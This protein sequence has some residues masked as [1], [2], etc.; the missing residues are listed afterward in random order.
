MGLP[1]PVMTISC[2]CG[3]IIQIFRSNPTDIDTYWCKNCAIR[4]TVG[5]GDLAEDEDEV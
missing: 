5:P 2:S 3:K 4:V 1:D